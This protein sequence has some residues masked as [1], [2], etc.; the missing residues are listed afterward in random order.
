MLHVPVSAPKNEAADGARQASIAEKSN[1]VDWKGHRPGDCLQN[2]DS[3]DAVIEGK[4]DC[5]DR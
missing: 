4:G 1:S 3:R 5:V 2:Y